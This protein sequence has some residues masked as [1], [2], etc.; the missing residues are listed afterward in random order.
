MN[1][2]Y[3]LLTEEQEDLRLMVREFADKE[4]IPTAKECDLPG[5]YPKDLFHKA[6]E[7]GLTTFTLPER[8]GGGGGDIF[9]WSLIKEEL[10]RGDA[11]F[12][13]SIAV[14]YMASVPIKIAGTDYHMKKLADVLTSGG[15]ACFALT[16]ASA[17]SDAAAMRTHYTREGEYFVLNGRKSFITSAPVADMFVVFATMDP[18]LRA[19][20]IS[21]F[22]VDGHSPGVSIGK[23]EDK[24]GF[25]TSMTS[26]VIFQDVKVPIANLIGKEGEGMEIAK[27]SLG[28][29]RPSSGAGAVGNAQYALECAVEYSKVRTTFGKPICKNQG[30]SFMLAD[31]YTKLEAARMMVWQSS[32]CADAGIFD[33]RLASAAKAFAADAGMQVCTDAVQILGGYGY[34]REYPVEKRFR[35]AK[36][37]QIFEGTNQ[38]QRMVIAGDILKG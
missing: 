20:G 10:A 22:L 17:G 18:T 29:T 28:R 2:Y 38:I 23:D 24:M 8:F 13:G 37:Y 35:D 21:A 3:H 11:G 9:T 34:S 27:A 4:I 12:S 36:L 19:K 5:T 31:M 14:C 6:Y 30:I 7:M 25:R 32:K 16:E 15:S 33:M 26:D 1:N